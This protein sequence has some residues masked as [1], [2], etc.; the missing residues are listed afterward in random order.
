M[1]TYTDPR[2]GERLPDEFA[3]EP[4]KPPPGDVLD[5]VAARPTRSGGPSSVAVII[6]AFVLVAIV[7]F[8]MNMG[9]NQPTPP[10]AQQS[11]ESVTPPAPEP[12]PPAQP[13]QTTNP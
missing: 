8:F 10:P 12:A 7:F 13:G 6:G 3:R 1:A 4:V 5:P 9:S 2:T 11:N